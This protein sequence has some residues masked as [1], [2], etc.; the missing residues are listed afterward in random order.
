MR[1]EKE[2]EK[3][4]EGGERET[5]SGT[6]W[7]QYI[8]AFV[9]ISKLVLNGFGISISRKFQFRLKTSVMI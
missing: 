6:R 9:D 1:C 5:E 7:T 8:N 4:G 3:E 2:R